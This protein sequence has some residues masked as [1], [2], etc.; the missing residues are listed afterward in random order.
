MDPSR[1]YIH[2]LQRAFSFIR[3]ERVL[4]LWSSTG[5]R[6]RKGSIAER[7]EAERESSR[8]LSSSPGPP[9]KFDYVELL[10]MR[11]GG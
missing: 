8:P 3:G 10:E 6:A 2:S 7:F 9:S 4:I 5:H 1:L 11:R